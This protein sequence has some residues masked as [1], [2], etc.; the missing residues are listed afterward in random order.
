[1]KR[2]QKE[3]KKT[4]ISPFKKGNRS[5]KSWIHKLSLKFSLRLLIKIHRLTNEH[6]VKSSSALMLDEKDNDEDVSLVVSE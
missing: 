2:L 6:W 4:Y 5:M 3:E 1:M